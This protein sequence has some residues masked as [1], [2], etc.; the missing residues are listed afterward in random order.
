M[1]CLELDLWKLGDNRISGEDHSQSGGGQPELQHLYDIKG[2]Y[3]N[4]FCL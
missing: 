1:S 3:N 4:E 2:D